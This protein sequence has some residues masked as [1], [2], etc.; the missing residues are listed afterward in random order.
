[1]ILHQSGRVESRVVFARA[2]SGEERGV[3][4]GSPYVEEGEGLYDPEPGIALKYPLLQNDTD[5]RV[6]QRVADVQKGLGL[7]WRQVLNVSS[8]FAPLSLNGCDAL[9]AAPRASTMTDASGFPVRLASGYYA[10]AG[11][12]DLSTCRKALQDAVMHDNRC[13]DP[14]LFSAQACYTSQVRTIA[15]RVCSRYDAQGD[16][17]LAECDCWGA[18]AMPGISRV[19]EACLAALARNP[20]KTVSTQELTGGWEKDVT[21]EDCARLDVGATGGAIGLPS[22]P[23]RISDAIFGNLLGRYVTRAQRKVDRLR[24]MPIQCAYAPCADRY[25]SAGYVDAGATQEGLSTCPAIRCE[26]L[27]NADWVTGDVTIT[28][29]VLDVNCD[30]GPCLERGLAKCRNG[31]RCIPG[32]GGDVTK[33]ICDCRG[34]GFKGENCEVQLAEGE[35]DPAW[36]DL[37]DRIAA[38]V[39]NDL[40]EIIDSID[41]PESVD[42]LVTALWVFIFVVLALLLYVLVRMATPSK[43]PAKGDAAD[44]TPA[45]FT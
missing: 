4:A 40:R 8:D 7:V 23:K 33:A 18:E 6:W 36:Q 16:I 27:I 14:H 42:V 17:Y 24:G 29:N 32:A 3:R 12:D 30:G 20:E 26:A 35:A 5:P 43:S 13:L 31:G 37:Q 21:E 38:G 41:S 45:N 9:Y 39:E 10:N 19:H 15:N 22:R 44:E 11:D 34:T 28:G 2:G 1:M 25:S